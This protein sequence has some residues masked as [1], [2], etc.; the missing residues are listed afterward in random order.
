M[1][2]PSPIKVAIALGDH[3]AEVDADAE[4]DAALGRQ[5]S[6]ALGHAVLD[7]NGTAHSINDASE[8]Q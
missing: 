7:F 3:V 4:F 1:L 6:V 2:T 5:S 8:T